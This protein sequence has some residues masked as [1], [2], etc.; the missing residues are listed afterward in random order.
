MVDRVSEDIIIAINIHDIVI[1]LNASS[2]ALR[3]PDKS[4][5]K[6]ET[7]LSTTKR[8]SLAKKLMK[9]IM[10]KLQ[11]MVLKAKEKLAIGP[12][13]KKS[14]L[15]LPNEILDEKVMEEVLKIDKRKLLEMVLNWRW[16]KKSPPKKEQRSRW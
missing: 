10:K 3:S 7:Q 12:I 8:R 1:N 6:N 5:M 13:D 2:F 9:K 4:L 16:S 15:K 14:E 11:Q